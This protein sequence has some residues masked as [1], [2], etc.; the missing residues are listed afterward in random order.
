M[1]LLLALVH[2]SCTVRRPAAWRSGSG[3]RHGSVCS[4][5]FL[6]LQAPPLSTRRLRG[7]L[8]KCR[9]APSQAL[10]RRRQPFVQECRYVAASAAAQRGE[11]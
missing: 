7:T 1:E 3:R 2:Q 8:P 10:Q 9:E 5:D 6:G 11:E 4:D